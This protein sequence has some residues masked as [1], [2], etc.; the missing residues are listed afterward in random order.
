MSQWWSVKR[1]A[2]VTDW[3][4][5]K[6]Q[7]TVFRSGLFICNFISLLSHFIV[8]LSQSMSSY[9]CSSSPNKLCAWRHDMPPPLSS[10]SGCRSASRRR[11]HRRACRRQRSSS[12]P[13]FWPIDLES[14]VRVT[15][16]VGYLCAI[17][18]GLRTVQTLQ[19][20]TANTLPGSTWKVWTVLRPT[21]RHLSFWWHREGQRYSSAR[22]SR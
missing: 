10:P 6:K 12:F 19:V 14:G 11:A 5:C 2:K 18:V 8:G 1:L 21:S 22:E 4:T 13:R 3:S 20:D 17:F 9:S 16:D 15:C 7:C